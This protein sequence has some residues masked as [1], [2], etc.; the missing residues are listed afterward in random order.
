MEW[1][2]IGITLNCKPYGEKHLLL[3]LL[4]HKNGL[5]KGLVQKKKG[6][7][8][9][10][11]GSIVSCYWKA[12]LQNH[13]GTYQIEILQTPFIHCFSSPQKMLFLK[14]ISDFLTNLLPESHAYPEMYQYFYELLENIKSQSDILYDYILFEILLLKTLGF[15][16][17]FE[18][19]CIMCKGK[20]KLYFF[21]PKTGN[22][23][24]YE[25]GLPYQDKLLAFDY[26]EFITKNNLS[27]KNY[28]QALRLTGFFIENHVIKQL[29]PS[30]KISFLRQ[31]FIQSC[32]LSAA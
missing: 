24:C 27:L 32:N 10:Q 19:N 29:I 4:T 6:F 23:S 18:E 7:Q 25:C 21:S 8:S 22:A 3:T 31:Q 15:G 11:S 9:I 16:I 28:H 30:K 2:D 26:E 14:T 12:R 17:N 13:L 20:K 5:S 1:Q